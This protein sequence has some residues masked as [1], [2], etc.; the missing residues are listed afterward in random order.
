MCKR[1]EVMGQHVWHAQAICFVVQIMMCAK[2]AA[3][4]SCW[5]SFGGQRA[6]QNVARTVDNTISKFEADMMV[7]SGDRWHA[8]RAALTDSASPLDFRI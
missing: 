1:V 3:L 6:L 2:Q 8:M 4:L 5:A 7:G